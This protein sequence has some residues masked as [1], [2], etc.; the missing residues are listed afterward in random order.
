MFFKRK[1]YFVFSAFYNIKVDNN[2]KGMVHQNFGHSYHEFPS[3]SKLE[4][5][6]KDFNKESEISGIV[7]LS[8]SE[9]N[10]K[11]YNKFWEL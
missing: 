10:K 7:I 1:R 9:L 5:I 8:I 3:K 6:I 2:Q 11:D 4:N